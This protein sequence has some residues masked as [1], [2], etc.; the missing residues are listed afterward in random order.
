MVVAGGLYDHK[1]EGLMSLLV[2]EGD[3]GVVLAANVRIGEGAE[4]G[5]KAG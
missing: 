5:V 3:G 4:K 2:V 1:Q